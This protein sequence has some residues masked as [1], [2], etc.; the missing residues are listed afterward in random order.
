[1]SALPANIAG[2]DRDGCAGLDALDPLRDLRQ[3]FDLPDD[4][5]YLDGNSLG[6]LPRGLAARVATTIER[7]WGQGLI[8]SWNSAGWIDLPQRAGDRIA[9]LIGAPPGS[10]LVGDSTSINLYKA[11]RAALGLMP[12]RAVILSDR[13]NFPTDLYIAQGICAASGGRL[14]LRLVAETELAAAVDADTAVV[15]ATQVNFRTGRLH[16]MAT[17]SAAA[18]GAGACMIW[19]LAHSAGALPVDIAGSGAGFAVG[20]GY[21]YLNGGPGAPGFLYVRPELQERIAPALSGWLGHAAPFDFAQ[22]YRPAAGIR[23]QQVGTP[24]IL[25]LLALDAALDLWAGVDMAQV[26]RKSLALS[27]L[28]IALVEARCGGFGL[29]LATPREHARRGS[30]V[31]F[32]CGPELRQG[33]P[34]MQALIAAGVIGDFR[35]PDLLRFGFAPLY[36]RHVDVFDAVDRLHDILV[37]RRW[38]N[39]AFHDRAAVT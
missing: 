1:M 23:R 26:R 34:V 12:G 3:A 24:P 21:K 39:P 9:T 7:D 30:Q 15:M 10:V 29:Q 8:R 25:S 5:I 16:D 11:L 19:D 4:V 2:I 22:D 13:G 36:L 18:S 35:A 17:V 20:C 27:D 28:F 32:A 38:D 37:Q 6:P 14:R 33:Y 31:S